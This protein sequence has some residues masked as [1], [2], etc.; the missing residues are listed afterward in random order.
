MNIIDE[1]VLGSLAA[2]ALDFKVSL[3]LGHPQIKHWN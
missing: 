3:F 1:K 2:Q